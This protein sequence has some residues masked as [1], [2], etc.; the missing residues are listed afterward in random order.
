[1]NIVIIAAHPDDEVLGCGATAA[2]LAREG[3]RIV[4]VIFCENATVR[5]TDQDMKDNLES[6]C[7]KSAAILGMQPPVFLGF[8]DQ[9][10]DTY[11]AL[12]LAQ[13]VET[14]LREYR[15]EMI[16][17]HHGGDV[18][19]DHQV[20][21]EATMV[22][23]RPQP[24]SQVKTVFAYETLSSTEWSATDYYSRFTPTTF[25]DVTDTLSLKIKAFKQYVSE[26]RPYPHPRSPEAIEYRARD[27]GARVGL[28]A[29]EAFRLVRAL[30]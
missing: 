6:W 12:E 29:A 5:Y 10:L 30:R 4:P 2:R 24:G 17:T 27:W 28:R 14:V 21:F 1:M 7:Q 13:A 22:A 20:L 25:Y 8:P 23:A 16:F 15:P 18:N 11:P 3:H 9:K 19:R 26:V